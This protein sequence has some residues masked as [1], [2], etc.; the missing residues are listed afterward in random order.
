MS[1]RS[2]SSCSRIPR[3]FAKIIY[4]K[5]DEGLQLHLLYCT[6]RSSLTHVVHALSKHRVFDGR[7][8]EIFASI[9]KGSLSGCTLA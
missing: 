1:P 8:F 7:P 5:L 9:R 4:G 3:F 6:Q 2:R